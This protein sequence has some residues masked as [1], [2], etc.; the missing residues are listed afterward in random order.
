MVARLREVAGLT[1]SF[2][3]TDKVAG[4]LRT[5]TM[6]LTS[7]LIKLDMVRLLLFV[8]CAFVEKGWGG[9]LCG[10]CLCWLLWGALGPFPSA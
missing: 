1:M 4:L 7:S 5:L 6:H 8:P 10:G 9:P 2:R 3:S